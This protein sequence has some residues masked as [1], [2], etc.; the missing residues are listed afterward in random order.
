VRVDDVRGVAGFI[1]PR[2]F[3]DVVLISE[4]PA[5]KRESY[6]DILLHHVKVLAIDQLASER[7]QHPTIAKAVTIEVTPEQAQK[8][9]LAT[10]IGRLS[11][12]LRGGF[13]HRPSFGRLLG[14]ASRLGV[15]HCQPIGRRRLT[16][17]GAELVT[18]IDIRGH[19]RRCAN[20]AAPSRQCLFQQ[21]AGVS[22]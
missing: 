3:V 2:D 17:A 7:Q 10:N 13:G 6:S 20:H 15:D 14:P 16:Q 1:L 12:V 19:S 22:K 5:A 8:I 9:L 4:D 21:R 18:R 11:L